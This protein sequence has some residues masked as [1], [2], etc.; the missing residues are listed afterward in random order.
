MSPD[1]E[2]DFHSDPG[3]GGGCASDG[4]GG[5]VGGVMWQRL[6]LLIVRAKPYEGNWRSPKPI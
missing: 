2:A 1:V 5:I 3:A 4:G 6:H